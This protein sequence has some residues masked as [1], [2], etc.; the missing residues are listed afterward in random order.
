M[1]G[2]GAMS[3]RVRD[4]AYHL[5]AELVR[6]VV[7]VEPITPVP[8]S[9]A[10]ARGLTS[11]RGR[12]VPVVDLSVLLGHPPSAIADG[13]RLLLVASGTRLLGLLVDRVDRLSAVPDGEPLDLAALLEAR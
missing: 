4:R 5:P 3:F 6:E 11:V 8:R 12:L 1:T 13:S 9:A 2:A 10:H 7:R